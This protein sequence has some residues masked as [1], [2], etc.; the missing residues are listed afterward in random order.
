MH[1]NITSNG[2]S[3]FSY[4]DSVIKTRRF[5]LIPRGWF[6]FRGRAFVEAVMDV[7]VAK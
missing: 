4:L 2:N 7:E 6:N 3:E 1:S 5:Q